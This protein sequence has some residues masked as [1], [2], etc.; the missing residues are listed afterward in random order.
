MCAQAELTNGLTFSTKTACEVSGEAAQTS[1][2]CEC[3]I[4]SKFEPPNRLSS[5]IN[6]QLRLRIK[7][8][9]LFRNCATAIKIVCR[10]AI[11]FVR[12]FV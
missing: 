12:Y 1:S 7:L 3:Q 11:I 8:S 2:D 4:L 5:A 10:S 6:S 9:F